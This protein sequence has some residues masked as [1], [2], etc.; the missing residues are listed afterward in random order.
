MASNNNSPDDHSVGYGRP[1]VH[2][3]FKKGIS[4]NPHGRP[5]GTRNFATILLA[6]LREKVVFNENGKRMVITKLD[7]ILKQLVN[8]AASGD[9]RATSQIVSLTPTAEEASAEHMDSKEVLHALD[10]RVVLNILKRYTQ[11]TQVKGVS[12][13]EEKAS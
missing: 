12:P 7:A 5:K 8:K 3:R 2:T 9:L 4:G 13:N 1:P 6:T 11:S 10:E